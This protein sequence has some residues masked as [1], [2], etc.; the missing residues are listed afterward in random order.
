LAFQ[1]ALA[2]ICPEPSIVSVNVDQQ[3]KDFQETSKLVVF[4]WAYLAL[5]APVA[6]F[7]AIMERKGECYARDMIAIELFSS[8]YLIEFK[9]VIL[10][11]ALKAFSFIYLNS[12]ESRPKII[13]FYDHK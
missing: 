3:F 11:K 13:F 10:F 7:I 12:K 6:G 4:F 5:W 2:F 1:I 9:N 8:F